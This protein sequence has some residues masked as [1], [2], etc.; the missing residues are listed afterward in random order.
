M[1]KVDDLR[2]D[3][4]VWIYSVFFKKKKTNRDLAGQWVICE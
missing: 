1:E 4:M 3:Q 2:P